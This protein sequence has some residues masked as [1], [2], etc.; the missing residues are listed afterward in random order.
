MEDQVELALDNYRIY[1]DYV[2]SEKASLL[3]QMKVE[4]KDSTDFKFLLSGSFAEGFPDSIDSDVDIMLT[5]TECI[6]TEW[7]EKLFVVLPDAPAHLKVILPEEFLE[8]F[9]GNFPI[10]AKTFSLVCTNAQE[11]VSYVSAKLLR[12]INVN[13]FLPDNW[14]GKKPSQS[15]DSNSDSLTSPSYCLR[16]NKCDRVTCDRVPAIECENWPAVA[17]EWLSRSPRYWPCEAMIKKIAKNGFS[18]VPKPTSLTGDVEKEWRFSFS[19]AEAELLQ[20]LK[21]N[22]RKVYYLLRSIYVNYLKKHGQTILTSYNI[23]TLVFWMLQDENPSFWEREKLSN[24]IIKVFRKLYGCLKNQFC[25]HFFLPEHNILYAVNA[26]DYAAAMNLVEKVLDNLEMVLITISNE[27]YLGLLPRFSL[28]TAETFCRH[29]KAILKM[30]EI[31][32]VSLL[33]PKTQQDI[34]TS[35]R[36]EEQ[37]MVSVLK[38]TIIAAKLVPTSSTMLEVNVPLVFVGYHLARAIKNDVPEVEF[39]EIA[40]EKFSKIYVVDMN[41]HFLIWFEI[42][43]LA[44]T[45]KLE[46]R[47]VRLFT[48]AQEIIPIIPIGPEDALNESV[49]RQLKVFRT[50]C[51]TVAAYMTGAKGHALTEKAEHVYEALDNALKS[52]EKKNTNDKFPERT[53][54][55]LAGG[56]FQVAAAKLE[57]KD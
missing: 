19:S 33:V 26:E 6:T 38:D 53:M 1:D 25:P 27:G 36:L 15:V 37:L 23:K 18:I 7:Q 21:G 42:F 57:A 32:A 20:S 48:F 12:D 28:L 11:N 30:E 46:G 41:Q 40:C 4:N 51:T 55:F 34:L 43:K 24:I 56:T 45:Y 39:D 10:I 31:E 9:R 2:K 13:D 8:D 17:S 16:S 50:M 3:L 14:Q 44:L 54:Y 49:L 35:K 22:A 52:F 29:T 47:N 5:L